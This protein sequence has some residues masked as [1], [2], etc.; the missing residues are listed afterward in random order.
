MSTPIPSV[1]ALPKNLTQ[2]GGASNASTMTT[3]A[4]SKDQF[5]KLLV[6]QLQHQDPLSPQSGADFVAQLAQITSVEQTAQTN[7]QL[8]DLANI[9]ASTA[10]TAMTGLMGKT[11]TTRASTLAVASHMRAWREELCRRTI[12]RADGPGH[13][14]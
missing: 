4:T 13:S 6:A 7:Q 5:L 12:D 1:S 11:I 8:A 3:S 2:S 14:R 9:Q 10:R